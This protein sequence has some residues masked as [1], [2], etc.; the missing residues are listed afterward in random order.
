MA[1]TAHASPRIEIDTR[2][3]RWPMERVIPRV[4]N[5]GIACNRDW[6]QLALEEYR[7]FRRGRGN[8]KSATYR[9]RYSLLTSLRRRRQN[10]RH[11]SLR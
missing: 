7:A 8:R 10:R 9:V 4:N 2:I 6:S 11:A 3:E 1:K 5:T